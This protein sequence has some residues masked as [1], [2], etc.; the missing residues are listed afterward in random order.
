MKLLSLAW[1][2]FRQS[3]R[4]FGGLILALAFAIMMIFCFGNMAESNVFGDPFSQSADRIRLMC[5][6][7]RVI[8]SFFAFLFLWY[9]MHA[10]LKARK[11]EF[12]TY[13]FMGLTPG[14]ICQLYALEMGL[15]ALV[16]IGLGLLGGIGLYRLLSAVIARFSGLPQTG[17]ISIHL[18]AVLQT[19]ALFAA[20]F[21]FFILIGMLSIQ[22]STILK[23]MNASAQHEGKHRP[24]WLLWIETIAGVT[25]MGAG[26]Y[27]VTVNS[28]NIFGILMSVVL[29]ISLG[30]YL[31]FAGIAPLSVDAL[32]KNR[33][34]LWRKTRTIWLSRLRWRIERSYR[35]YA[36]VSILILS[37]MTA[38]CA[39][40]GFKNHAA[41]MEQT[42]LQY[43]F[44]IVSSN[45]NL[46]ESLASVISQDQVITAQ[47]EVSMK[48][49]G[50]TIVLGDQEMRN[51]AAANGLEW[52]FAPLE[53][54]Q[55]IHIKRAH[56]LATMITTP[57]REIDVEDALA[58]IVGTTADP[59]LGLIQGQSDLYVLSQNRYDALNGSPL[60]YLYNFSI[61]N[62]DGYGVSQ[63]KI[64]AVAGV[65]G[66][67]AIGSTS[68]ELDWIKTLFAFALFIFIVLIVCAVAM[69]SIKTISDASSDREDHQVLSHAGFPN[70]ALRQ[71]AACEI[72]VPFVLT[73]VISALGGWFAWYSISRAI[74]SVSLSVY[75]ISS[76]AVLALLLVFYLICLRSYLQAAGIGS[77]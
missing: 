55:A 54:N 65:E 45:G 14:R 75:F 60:L 48:Q 5:D 49:T 53:D 62:P 31:L 69:L 39:G 46:L 36:M 8:L 16:S 42:D 10:F 6:I 21:V 29:M 71:A 25:L 77:R 24:A 13:I 37:A 51:L 22:S 56:E 18:S 27:L 52:N 11:K 30:V 34:F 68:S 19:L 4:S 40:I 32:L 66:V 20:F 57:V 72:A 3:M 15:S 44:Q 7:V 50:E 38:L 47:S 17:E 2:N 35:T 9:A 33:R 26:F 61:Q 59:Y 28:D 58:T 1:M 43:N 70:G 23:L 63:P 64:E 73:F 12:G 41:V 67:Y 74:D 76:G